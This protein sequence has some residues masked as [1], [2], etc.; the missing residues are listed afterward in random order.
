MIEIR[1][2]ETDEVRTLSLIDPDSGVDFVQDFIGN[3]GGFEGGI[4]TYNGDEYECSKDTFDW[5]EKVI[6]DQQK[7]VDRIQDL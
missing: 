6:D 7:L 4:F 5:W 2:V 1:I 3:N